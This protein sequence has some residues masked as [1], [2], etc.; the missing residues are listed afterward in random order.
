MKQRYK[1]YP[2]FKPDY[3]PKEMFLQ[4]IFGGSYFR[5][6]YSSVL[7]KTLDSE[8]HQDIKFLKTIPKNLYY[9]QN[10][11]DVVRNKYKI[12][13]SLPLEYWEE[14]GWINK[15][16]P[17]GWVQW[18]CRFNQGRRVKEE[19]DRQIR[20]F[21]KFILRFGQKEDYTQKQKQALLQWGI[22][23]S[24]NHSRYIKEIKEFF[25]EKK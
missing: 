6:V 16:D 15:I 10:V 23:Y 9:S 7:G 1:D 25:K 13:A 8:D 22:D 17:Y 12:H 2:I 19:D 5:R 11:K 14:K 20:R 21:L 24:K 4:G 3:S 18:Y